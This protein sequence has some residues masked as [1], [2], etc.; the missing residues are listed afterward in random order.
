MR[1]CKCVKIVESDKHYFPL[2]LGEIYYYEFD[3]IYEDI[4]CDYNDEGYTKII[5]YCSIYTL[6]NHLIV[7]AS[8]GSDFF[9]DRFKDLSELRCEII[10][11]LLSK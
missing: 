10:N 9:V 1:K 11:K 6:D 4:E 7:S 2:V 5:E 8:S 3:T